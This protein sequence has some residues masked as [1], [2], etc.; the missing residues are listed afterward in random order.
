M[1]LD[2][3][4]GPDAGRTDTGSFVSAFDNRPDSLEIRIPP[5]LRDVVRVTDIIAK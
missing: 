5:A 4:A 1:R 3:L 2:D